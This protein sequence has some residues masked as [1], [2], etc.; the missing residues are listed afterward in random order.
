MVQDRGEV[1]LG[2]PARDGGQ[3]QRLVDLPGA[4]DTGQLNGLGH[5]GADPGGA[6]GAGLDQPA[7]RTLA[8]PKEGDLLNGAWSGLG[9][10]DMA[11]AGMV[12]VVLV[13]DARS[14][15]RGQPVAAQLLQ[16][17]GTAA[18]DDQLLALGAAP[19]GLA[20]PARRGRVPHPAPADRLVLLHQPVGTQRQRVRG[21]RKHVQVRPL[22]GQPHG[23]GLPGLAVLA[24]VDLLQDPLA[25]PGQLG[26]RRVVAE[27]VGAGG[28]QVGLGELHR[29]LHPAL[30]LRIVGDTGLHLAAVV[31]AHRHHLGVADRDAGHVL[32]GHGLGVVRQ[33]VGRRSAQP[34]QRLVQAGHQRRKGLVP[35]RDD[36][37]VARPGQPRAEQA[38]ATLA[39]PGAV[40][41]VELQPHARLRHPG[42]VGAAVT[43]PPG[44]L[45]FRDGAPSGP[46]RA[47]KPHRDQAVV[48]DVGADLAGG[49]VDQLLELGQELVDAAGTAGA[50]KRVGAG[51]THGDV[52][53][54]GLGVAADQLRGRPGA[55][56]QVEGFEDLHDLP[57]RLGQRSLRVAAS[58][59]APEA[60][61]AGGTACTGGQVH[62]LG[63]PVATH[64]DF[65]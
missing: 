44:G 37:P 29:R 13:G 18:D 50:G 24:V 7:V 25:R 19:H 57:G 16:A 11:A 60:N 9:R 58:R 53:G 3:A 21:G 38:G 23:R 27:Q 49:A 33:Q 61:P 59:L 64:P 30:A 31:A 20:A 14:A 12:G 47:G 45:E 36:H 35:G 42:P 6:G 54:D 2:E 1:V 39:D 56:G 62:E 52:G 10:V 4:E 46:V 55:A 51:V 32:D 17:V 65:S 43:G 34:A 28:D 26:E 15:W 48:G 8:E 41:P 63:L 5:L 22:G 40:A